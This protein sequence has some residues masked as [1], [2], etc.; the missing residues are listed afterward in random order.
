MQK[1]SQEKIV[2]FFVLLLGW[3]LCIKQI[4]EPD[5]WWQ[6]RAG[7]WMLENFEITRTDVFSYT[8]SGVN[9]INVKW[10]YEVVFASLASFMGPEAVVLLQ[11]LSVS[12]IMLCLMQIALSFSKAKEYFLPASA[13]SILV[14][15]FIHSA[16]INLRPEMSTYALTALYFLIFVKFKESRKVTWLYILIPLQILWTNLHEAYGVGLVMILVFGLS[17]VFEFILYKWK[18]LNFKVELDKKFFI[19]LLLSFLALGVNP[20]GFSLLQHNYEIFSQLQTN[21]YTSE[22]L[23]VTS[24]LYWSKATVLNMFLFVLAI[25][26]FLFNKSKRSWM[27]YSGELIKEFGL[28]YIVLFF[29]FFYLGLKA[30]RNAFFFAFISFPLY[31]QWFQLMF[32]KFFKKESYALFGVLALAIVFYISVVTNVYY[33]LWHSSDRFGIGVNREKNPIGASDFIK[34]NNLKGNGF[35]DYFSS[36]YLMWSLQ[37]EFKTYIDMRDLDIFEENFMSNIMK[38]H[39]QPDLILKNGQELFTFMDGVDNFNYVMMLNSDIFDNFNSYMHAQDNFSLAY[40]DGLNSIYLRRT[41]ENEA[42]IASFNYRVINSD[43]F[44]E[45]GE[46]KEKAWTKIVT[47]IFWPFYKEKEFSQEYY[48]RME[49]VYRSKFNF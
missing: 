25:I 23:D 13:L 31:F 42:L 19:P 9:W 12:V 34:S 3:V 49:N 18:L 45:Y 6:L 21:N 28:F 4:K 22:L 43:F 40:V 5:L 2:F 39:Y 16:R 26:Y 27:V 47:K 7:E 38:A 33:Q 10:L 11:V 20:H 14:F 29:A 32:S 37:P 36:S 17:Q 35:V 24:P 30:Q 48:L 46:W 41:Q 44:S 8:Y 1:S 15:L